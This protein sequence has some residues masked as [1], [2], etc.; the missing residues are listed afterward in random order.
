MEPY[1]VFEL[2][3]KILNLKKMPKLELQIQKCTKKTGENFLKCQNW[4]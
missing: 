2:G 3:P 4:D 1:F